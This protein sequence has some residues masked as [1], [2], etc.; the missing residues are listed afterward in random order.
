MFSRHDR[1][2]YSF[3]SNINKPVANLAKLYPHIS[4]VLVNGELKKICEIKGKLFQR[5]LLYGLNAEKNYYGFLIPVFYGGKL[6]VSLFYCCT[7]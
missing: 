5:V 3:L 7:P 1:I 4:K 2:M 6:S